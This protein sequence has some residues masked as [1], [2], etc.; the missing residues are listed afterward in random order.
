MQAPPNISRRDCARAM[1]AVG[2]DHAI[3]REELRADARTR[4]GRLARHKSQCDHDCA[5]CGRADVSQ[6]GRLPHAATIS[7]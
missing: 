6:S 4:R 3:L 1:R 2:L 5:C 7:C